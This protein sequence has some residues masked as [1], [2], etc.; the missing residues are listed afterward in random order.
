MA[1]NNNLEIQ[2]S[3]IDQASQILV[4]VSREMAGL[5]DN[6]DKTAAPTRSLNDAINSV[7]APFAKFNSLMGAIPAMAAVVAIKKVADGFMSL[8]RGAAEAE[9]AQKQL[10]I[11]LDLQGPAAAEYAV[12][13]DGLAG[14]LQT[15]TG[16]DDEATKSAMALGLQMGIQADNMEQ[17]AMVSA[18]LSAALGMDYTSAMRMVAQAGEGNIMMLRRQIPALRD[19]SIEGK[20]AA[21][22]YQ[23]IGDRV[24][25]TAALM[26]TT[27]TASMERLKNTIGDLGQAIGGVLLPAF[28]SITNALTP[29]IAQLAKSIEMHTKLKNIDALTG[30]AEVETYIFKLNMQVTE[31]SQRL[32]EGLKPYQ[33]ELDV[34]Q[35]L[36]NQALKM[37][38]MHQGDSYYAKILAEAADRLQRAKDAVWIQEKLITD[39]IAKQ[40]TE[41]NNQLAQLHMRQK[42]LKETLN[43]GDTGGAEPVGTGTSTQETITTEMSTQVGLSQMQIDKMLEIIEYAG[44]IQHIWYTINAELRTAVALG[45]ELAKG[46]SGTTAKESAGSAASNGSG[47]TASGKKEKDLAGQMTIFQQLLNQTGLNFS[48]LDGFLISVVSQTEAFARVMTL[49]NPL[50]DAVDMILT[51]IV[52]AL[53][54][55]FVGV[56]KI[57]IP[58][59]DLVSRP[60]VFLGEIL[61]WLGE[62]VVA[63]G[64]VIWYAVTF[65]WGKIKSIDWGETFSSMI[66]G[67]WEKFIAPLT[68]VSN[69]S[70]ESIASSTGGSSATYTQAR[71]ITINQ[72]FYTGY[73]VGEDGFRQF[74][75]EIVEEA[76]SALALAGQ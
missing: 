1:G 30:L 27:A 70:E 39:E 73:V 60:A 36:Y 72:Y 71:A 7:N 53:M 69:L 13:L 65:Q 4:K 43:Q 54:P 15:L 76:R 42:I 26:G 14:E 31:I 74:A 63:F 52:D 75:V 3:A 58:A 66:S 44:T 55:M 8:M 38:D 12:R 5:K 57:L 23:I 64:Q 21:E 68:D 62:K 61:G 35:A 17:A 46:E 20:S 9:R 45:G 41:L 47:E 33:E 32:K 25:G 37:A 28:T 59:I 49:I 19:V 22:I 18:D 48:S 40:T 29:Y 6:T 2:I 34:A 56:L 10:F 11:A 16:M 51:P 24:K 50:I 67:A